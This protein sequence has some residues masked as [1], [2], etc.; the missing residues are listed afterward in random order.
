ML[1]RSPVELSEARARA[2]NEMEV[3]AELDMLTSALGLDPDADIDWGQTS[4]AYNRSL[5]RTD[6]E[7]LYDWARGR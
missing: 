3:M 7:D 4:D 5:P 2:K 6:G 1:F